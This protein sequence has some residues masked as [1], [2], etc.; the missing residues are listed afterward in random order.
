VFV[1]PLDQKAFFDIAH[2]KHARD[3]NR[4]IEVLIYQET[5]NTETFWLM[6]LHYSDNFL[7]ST[8]HTFVAIASSPARSSKILSS[9]ASCDDFA[10]H[11]DV[12]SC[13]PEV[14]TARSAKRRAVLHPTVPRRQISASDTSNASSTWWGKQSLR[15]FCTDST[16]ESKGT[17]KNE[18]KNRA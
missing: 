17:T 15:S 2:W 8:S 9:A 7:Y 5:A 18:G 10:S 14:K 4:N 6:A 1:K 13:I 16:S 11:G 12:L 3:S